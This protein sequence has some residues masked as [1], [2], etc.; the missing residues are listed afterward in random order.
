M[1]LQ[2]N[3][4]HPGAVVSTDQF[5]SSLLGRLPH[6]FG[7]ESDKEKFCGGT[8]FV[9]EASEFVSVTNQ[10]SLNASETLLAKG[11]F[12]RNALQHGVTIK[13][14]RGDNGTYRSAEFQVDLK[15]KNQPMVYSGIGAHHH[16]GV[17]ERAIRTIST[18]ARTMLLHAMIHWPSETSLDLWPF[19]VDYA[20]YLWNLLPREPSG[21]SPNELFYGIKSDHSDLRNAKVWGCPTYVLDPRLQ[22]GK[23]IPRWEPRSKLGQFVGR[24]LIHSSSVGLIKNT[25]TGNVSAQFHVVYDNHFTTLD[26]LSK[27]TPEQIPPEWID[28]FTY[29]RE[30]F[31]DPADA[32]TGIPPPTTNHTLPPLP[33]PSSLSVPS[34]N[35]PSTT[36]PEGATKS[37]VPE[38][39]THPVSEPDTMPPVSSLP[40]SP[41]TTTSNNVFDSSSPISHDLETSV[42]H[43]SLPSPSTSSI[44]APSSPR[45]S[46]RSRVFNTR[47]FNKDFVNHFDLHYQAFLQDFNQLSFH[48]AFLAYHPLS[49][50]SSMTEQFALIHELRN[51]PADL[52]NFQGLHPLAFSA[53]INAEDTPK[54]HE[55]MASPD[56]EGFLQAMHKEIEQLEGLQAWNVVPRSKAIE[57]GRKVI[58]STWVFKRKR[59]PDGSLKKLKARI[60]VRGD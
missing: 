13:S 44:Q 7:K 1:S 59:Y 8:V 22:D 35:S 3:S 12:E 28:L 43:S 38:G 50:S 19:A 42:P 21:L 11:K 34:M 25:A 56:Q 23:K 51:D 33:A 53:Q 36:A 46:T 9:D 55:A 37:L 24:S 5:V 31:Y 58:S 40:P 54:L 4:L 49:A 15:R 26:I 10:V 30:N 29:Q 47:Y 39:A 2:R 20:V 57:A 45:R 52:D 17:A 32:P 41:S 18:N 60:C 14:Y 27:P 16:N 48:D 6:M